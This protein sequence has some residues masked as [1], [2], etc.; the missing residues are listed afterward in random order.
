M[1]NAKDDAD[2]LSLGSVAVGA[3]HVKSDRGLHDLVAVKHGPCGTPPTT[4]G[5]VPAVANTLVDDD[6][7][8][9]SLPITPPSSPVRGQHLNPVSSRTAVLRGPSRSSQRSLAE[10]SSLRAWCTRTT[11]VGRC[12]C[13]C[14]VCEVRGEVDGAG[15]VGE[16]VEEER[17]RRRVTSA[18]R[19]KRRGRGGG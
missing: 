19:S 1:G 12:F 10:H 14:F 11:W 3:V 6:A 16:E 5:D 8:D 18:R 2:E 9:A 13:V 7:A 15:D 4:V 17:K